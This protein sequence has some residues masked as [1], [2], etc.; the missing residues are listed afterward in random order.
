[1]LKRD[2]NLLESYRYV[3]KARSE[4]T[5]PTVMYVGIIFIVALSLGVYSLKLLFDNLTIENQI[6][7]IEDYINDP[8]VVRKLNEISTMQNNIKQLDEL[9]TE[10]AS[11]ID[12]LDYIPRFDNEILKILLDNLPEGINITL[13]TYLDSWISL[14]I[15]GQFASD[16][17]NY[18][19][20][21][22][23]TEFFKD[24]VF[25]GYKYDAS[26]R[27]YIGIVKVQMKGGN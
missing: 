24:V 6:V 25:E 17:S 13:V 20:R 27:R 15:S 10:V 21:L 9:N 12:V 2:M 26:S 22:Q 11:I 7:S 1:M 18:A 8:M 14:E 4:K 16:P 3:Q 23:R 5:N 19:L